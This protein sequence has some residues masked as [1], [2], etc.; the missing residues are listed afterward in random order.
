MTLCKNNL[1]K[2]CRTISLT[3]SVQ[4]G[5]WKLVWKCLKVVKAMI[6]IT[7]AEAL[8]ASDTP[9]LPP[10]FLSR[11]ILRI[12]WNNHLFGFGGILKI[13][14]EPPWVSWKSLQRRSGNPGLILWQVLWFSENQGSQVKTSSFLFLRT[15]KQ[16]GGVH[17]AHAHFSPA[18]SVWQ[19]LKKREQHN[20][21]TTTTLVKCN[22]CK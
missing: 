10:L 6:P 4:G 22:N 14:K 9:T 15:A 19:V 12:L 8:E 5:G 11:L 18:S 21:T 20:T 7:V 13:F 2:K 1:P 16:R 3:W 17:N